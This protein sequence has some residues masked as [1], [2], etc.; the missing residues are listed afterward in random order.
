MALVWYLLT[1]TFNAKCMMYYKRVGVMSCSFSL[2][3]LS[4]W[5]KESLCVDFRAVWLI[6]FR[7]KDFYSFNSGFDSPLVTSE[8]P[9]P[10]VRRRSCGVD[11]TP[12]S[13]LCFGLCLTPENSQATPSQRRLQYQ[14]TPSGFTLWTKLVCSQESTGFCTKPCV[15]QT[16]VIQ[17]F[18]RQQLQMSQ[19]VYLYR[20]CHL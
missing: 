10:T 19:L 13:Q 2:H 8:K 15:K 5:K 14:Y 11:H 18:E 3:F 6:I 20:T 1:M 16:D 17:T 9:H 12:C 7:P 4:L